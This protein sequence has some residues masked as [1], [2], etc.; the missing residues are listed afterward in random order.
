MFEKLI[1]RR[2]FAAGLML[3]LW[4]NQVARADQNSEIISATNKGVFSQ[5]KISARVGIDT[6]HLGLG[7]EVQVRNLFVNEL[8]F[9]LPLSARSQAQAKSLS[10]GVYFPFSS[11]DL[12]YIA[13][14]FSFFWQDS[15]VVYPVG[16]RLKF[17]ISPIVFTVSTSLALGADQMSQKS[18]FILEYR[19]NGSDAESSIMGIEL[20]HL[21][22]AESKSV[23]NA[24]I[25]AGVQF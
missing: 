8:S 18:R 14:E 13:P 16:V 20:L 17:P 11:G 24:S 5:I 2:L 6:P 3:A 21:A 19:L 25:M 7:S 15:R 9:D 22:R 23:L 1:G 12:F 4:A 10:E